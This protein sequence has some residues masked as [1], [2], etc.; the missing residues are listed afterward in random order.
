MIRATEKLIG[1]RKQSFLTVK[2]DLEKFQVSV[3]EEGEKLIPHSCK[4]F[5]AK[6]E[7]II[8][9]LLH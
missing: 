1:E 6:R 3:E 2:L 4:I 7:T 9:R 8:F 5:A